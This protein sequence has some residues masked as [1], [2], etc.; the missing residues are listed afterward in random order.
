MTDNMSPV[1]AK[2][3]EIE[4][5]LV[6]QSEGGHYSHICS[7]RWQQIALFRRFSDVLRADP[8]N[9]DVCL[10]PRPQR[11]HLTMLTWTEAQ[12]TSTMCPLILCAS[13]FSGPQRNYSTAVTQRFDFPIKPVHRTAFQLVQSVGSRASAEQVTVNHTTVTCNQIT[14]ESR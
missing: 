8:E 11:G 14:T 10:L 12:I 1:L 7:S 13:E 2:L 3:R 6:C 9:A 4:C 5:V